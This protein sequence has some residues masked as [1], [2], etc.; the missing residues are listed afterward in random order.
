MVENLFSRFVKLDQA[1]VARSDRGVGAI[2]AGVIVRVVPKEV[3][4]PGGPGVIEKG[5][6]V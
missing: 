3:T 6:K 4:F 2:A 5:A 1:V